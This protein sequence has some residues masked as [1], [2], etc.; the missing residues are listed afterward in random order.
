MDQVYC[1]HEEDQRAKFG[2][3]IDGN[4]LQ[5]CRRCR[6]PVLESIMVAAARDDVPQVLLA[7]VPEI[8][9]LRIGGYRGLVSATVAERAT[10][11][12]GQSGNVL[13]DALD[14]VRRQAGTLG[15]NAIVGLQ[16]QAAAPGSAA[17]VML[18]GTAVIVEAPAPHD[19]APS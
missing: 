14:E 11:T 6:R 16:M 9:G 19:V 15:A 3:D 7:T 4:G 18:M 2:V 10:A 12:P 13:A 5:I 8:A 17:V 1:F